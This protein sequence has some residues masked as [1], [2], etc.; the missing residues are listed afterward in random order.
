MKVLCPIILVLIGLAVSKVKFKWSSDPW[1]MDILYIGKL[2]V[3]FSSING[4]ENINDYHFSDTYI[5]V[6]C[7][8]LNLDNFSLD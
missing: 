4:I 7:E 5:N 8:T 3:L 6:T 2:I 1:R